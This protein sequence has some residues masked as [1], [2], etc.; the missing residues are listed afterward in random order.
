MRRIK[1]HI[2][3]KNKSLFIIANKTTKIL[4]KNVVSQE[5]GLLSESSTLN[6]ERK[7][8]PFLK[9]TDEVGIIN[10]LNNECRAL[11]DIEQ[12]EAIITSSIDPYNSVYTVATLEK[13]YDGR[14]NLTFESFGKTVLCL[15]GLDVNL[16]KEI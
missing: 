14:Y 7:G 4:F 6:I 13:F 5:D 9:D 12:E 3:Y 1:A 11:L 8:Y 16:E 10:F 2:D 15:R